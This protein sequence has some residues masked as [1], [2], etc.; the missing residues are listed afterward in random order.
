MELAPRLWMGCVPLV[1][2]W[3]RCPAGSIFWRPNR[4]SLIEIQHIHQWCI[5]WFIQCIFPPG[6]ATWRRSNPGLLAHWRGALR[7]FKQSRISSAT[8]PA[9]L[10]L[11]TDT[12]EGNAPLLPHE[13]MENVWSNH[14]LTALSNQRGAEGSQKPHTRTTQTFSSKA[15]NHNQQKTS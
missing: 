9:A 1:N 4:W 14:T 8:R 2:M 10:P 12:Q 5:K 3:S 7:G 6:L 11:C 13:S 15:N